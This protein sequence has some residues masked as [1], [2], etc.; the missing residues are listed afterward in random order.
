VTLH[1][2][3][4]GW[5]SAPSAPSDLETLDPDVYATLFLTPGKGP[6]RGLVVEDVSSGIENEALVVAR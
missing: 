5:R 1:R 4:H 2:S 6:W 3:V